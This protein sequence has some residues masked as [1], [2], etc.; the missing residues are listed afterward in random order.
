[1]FRNKA[2]TYAVRAV[3]EIA[4]RRAAGLMTGIQAFE[5][6]QVYGLP[7]A[8]QPVAKVLLTHRVYWE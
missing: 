1:M 7:T 6:A 3:L 8:Y 2:L 5:I 4:K